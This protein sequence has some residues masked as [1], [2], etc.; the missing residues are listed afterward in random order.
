MFI[1]LA[2]LKLKIMENL[3]VL[4]RC[5]KTFNVFKLSL[6][7]LYSQTSFRQILCSNNSS[8]MCPLEH[9]SFVTDH[10][11]P[12]SNSFNLPSAVAN[13]Q[14]R[15]HDRINSQVRNIN[16][17]VGNY[18]N[19][20][21]CNTFLL[22]NHWLWRVYHIMDDCVTWLLLSCLFMFY[23]WQSS[24]FK[25]YISL[26]SLINIGLSRI[27]KRDWR[28]VRRWIK[29]TRCLIHRRYCFPV[30]GRNGLI[31]LG[32]RSRWPWH[33]GLQRL[34]WIRGRYLLDQKLSLRCAFRSIT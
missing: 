12:C 11:S 24:S 22:Y 13:V 19:Q 29:T 18:W 34:T 30:P 31:W 6:V 27:T 32:W 25:H 17:A 5:F 7:S 15:A 23:F 14:A 33:C 26:F 21:K 8:T 1:V 9:K 16:T 3:K 2:S 28:R 10:M 20:L 4:C